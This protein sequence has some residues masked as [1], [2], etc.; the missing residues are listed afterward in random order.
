M[1][2]KGAAE[3]AVESAGIHR[4]SL[5][6]PSLLV[7]PNIRYG[8]QDRVTQRVF[9]LIQPLLP[10]R[11]H[12]IRVEDLA[13]AMRINAERPGTPGVEI[14]HYPQFVRLLGPIGYS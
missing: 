3:Q 1:R 10:A 6:R 7:T 5:F 9:P 8:L 2:T 12:A 11:Y 13:R 14:L 4:T